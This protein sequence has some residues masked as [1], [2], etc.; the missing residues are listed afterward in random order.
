MELETAF[1]IM[2]IIYMGLMFI[3]T[4]ALVIAVFVIKHK[5]HVIQNSI[6]ERFHSLIN[7]LQMGEA[8]FDKAKSA[9]KKKS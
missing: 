5:V 6:E 1:Y 7:A 8:I 9:F 3:L 4:L 2:A